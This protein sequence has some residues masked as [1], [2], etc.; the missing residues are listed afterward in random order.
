MVNDPT[1]FESGN[2]LDLI[3]KLTLY[4]ITGN[5]HNR[6]CEFG[7]SGRRRGGSRLPIL[8]SSSGVK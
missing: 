7:L 4:G 2:I 1:S 8:R 3:S 6:E 5:T